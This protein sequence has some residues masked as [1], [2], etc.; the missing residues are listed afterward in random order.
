MSDKN[1]NSDSFTPKLIAGLSLIAV[2]LVLGIVSLLCLALVESR[3]AAE[4]HRRIQQLCGTIMH[5]DE[6]LTMSAKMCAATGNMQ[7]KD[8][9][10][11]HESEL[12]RVI[13]EAGPYPSFFAL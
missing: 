9:Y 1:A 10:D 6:V 13:Q 7:W 3:T 8:R 5:L 12:D 11:R 2:V 4:R